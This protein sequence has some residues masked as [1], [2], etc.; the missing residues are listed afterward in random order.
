LA[1]Y[2]KHYIGI[3]S[4]GSLID[5]ATSLITP[6]LRGKIEFKAASAIKTGLS[7]QEV[8]VVFMLCAFHEI[9]I[10]EQGIAL[11]EA[12]RVLKPE[13]RIVIVDPEAA[14]TGSIMALCCAVH[15]N[16]KYFDHSV[17]VNHSKRVI[18]K[19]AKDFGLKVNYGKY[20][21]DWQFDDFNN[22]KNSIIVDF[23]EIEW[24]DEKKKTVA[25]LI[26]EIIKDKEFLKPIIVSDHMEVTVIG[27]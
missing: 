18:E 26:R 22:L 12:L 14:P 1:K 2:A 20:D 5:K 15:S 23:P 4:D 9:S 25:N 27:K 19:I 21:I 6:D 11:L 10:Q 7:D 8:D 13:G 24:N 16:F 17:I 3:D